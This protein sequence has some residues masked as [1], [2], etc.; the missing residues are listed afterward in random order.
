MNYLMIQNLGVAP[1]EG[2]TLL[3]L[4]T[5]RDCGVDGT[6]GQFGS[7]AKH[8]INVL[9][10]AKLKFW[11]YCGKTRLDFFTKEETIGDGLT[12]KTVNK[13][14]C[15]LGGTSSRTHDCG[16]CLDFG[17]I[18]W[19]D[20]AMA[21]REFISNAIDRTIREKN[22]FIQP[23]SGGDLAV[24]P[25]TEDQRRAKDGFTR[26]YIEMSPEVQRYYGELPS[27]FLHFSAIPAQVGMSLLPKADRNLGDGS[28]T[29]MIYRNGVLVREINDVKRP[30]LFDYNFK[31][32]ELS[33]DECR[34]SSEFATRAACAKLIRKATK[35]QLAIIFKSLGRQDDIFE[36]ELD[37]YYLCPTYADPTT[38]EKTA[39]QDGW[40]EA[41]G[42]A[43][44]CDA[45]TT[46]S[47]EIAEV[48]QKKGHLTKSIKA[49][50]WAQNAKRFGIKTAETVLSHN[51][52]KGR[53]EIPATAAANAAVDEVWGWLETLKMTQ[54][55]PRPNVCC[56][57]DIMSGEC[58]CHG[59][60]DGDWVYL[61]E[62]HCGARTKFLL[63]V[64]LE[65]C[66]HY[67]TDATDNSRDFQSFI[68]DMFVEMA[69]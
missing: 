41:N 28:L 7:G 19:N 61:R 47:K 57:R 6:I 64:A 33:I 18:D 37:S 45:T 21:L 59:Y 26:I 65:E 5:T 69:A 27:R 32:H 39:W 53:D 16:W 31:P 10:R 9:L 1:V 30:S 25:Q 8:A 51:E 50:A 54:G 58:S 36:A 17:S 48:V 44:L 29:P 35:G 11:I 23:L 60:Q 63:K 34:N 38:E 3:G 15:R 4:S 14:M 55:K 49:P 12:E 42:D 62:D 46:G 2:Y 67:V 24:I 22:D 13:V 20:T 43:I 40:K 56:F 66:V 52:Q 68:L